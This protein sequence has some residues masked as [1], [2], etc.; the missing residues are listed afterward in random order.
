MHVY[1]EG[2]HL[3]NFT[4]PHPFRSDSDLS[5]WTPKI[6][7]GLRSDSDDSDWSPRSPTGVSSDSDRNLIRLDLGVFLRQF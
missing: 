2:A 5:D 6:P 4:L 1:N 7:I 3:V